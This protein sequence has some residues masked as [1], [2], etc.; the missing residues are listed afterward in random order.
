MRLC[1]KNSITKSCQHS[2]QM[3]FDGQISRLRS[4]GYPLSLLASVTEGLLRDLKFG[5]GAKIPRDRTTRPIVVPYMHTFSHGLKKIAN[6]A[7]VNVVF[8]APHKLYSLCKKVN[9]PS[10][11][12]TVSCS[13]KHKS[14][15][16][17]CVEG[18]IY[19]FPLSCGKE[20]IGQT[21]RCL[22]DRLR[23]H[24]NNI[25]SANSGH[26][27]IH[28]RDCGCSARMEN[29]AVLGKSKN[30]LTREIIEAANIARRDSRCVST[31]SLTLS[32]KELNY[33][34]TRCNRQ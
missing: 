15:F 27:G 8:S 3:S 18:V 17:A 14:N 29:C 5:I 10:P 12:S 32:A 22:N 2:M 9:S 13:K 31:P 30:Q 28:C 33:L 24:T 19:S 20:Y 1:L 34:G 6:R 25:V 16:V 7:N 23:E 4:A 11:L 26:L 21:G